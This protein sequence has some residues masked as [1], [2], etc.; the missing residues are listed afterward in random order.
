MKKVLDQYKIIWEGRE[1]KVHIIVS[2]E[3]IL[4][5]I[6]LFIPYKIWIFKKNV[7]QAIEYKNNWNYWLIIIIMIYFNII[8]FKKKLMLVNKLKKQF[9]NNSNGWFRVL[10]LITDFE[11][12]LLGNAKRLS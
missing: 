2:F 3:N 6:L 9:L 4:S 7:Q 5:S 8:K 10:F 11:C 1:K 12:C